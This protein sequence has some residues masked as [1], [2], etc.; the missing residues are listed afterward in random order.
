[1][2]K[3]ISS[4]ILG[5][6]LA[7]VFVPNLLLAQLDKPNECCRVRA[8]VKITIDDVLSGKIGIEFTDTP[9]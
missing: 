5:F 9:L 1:M 4:V 6:L 8:K 7:G 3:I 2:K